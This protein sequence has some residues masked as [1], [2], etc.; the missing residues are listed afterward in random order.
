MNKYLKSSIVISSFLNFTYAANA[1]YNTA[2]PVEITGIISNKEL[3]Q[4]HLK[5]LKDHPEAP[6]DSQLW[7]DSEKYVPDHI[8]FMKVKSN[9]RYI[10]SDVSEPISNTPLATYSAS[11]ILPLPTGPLDQG[12][13]GTCTTFSAIGA[14]ISASNWTNYSIQPSPSCLLNFMVSDSQG[15][16]NPWNGATTYRVLSTLWKA[17]IIKTSTGNTGFCNANYPVYEPYGS[18]AQSGQGLTTSFNTYDS[19]ITWP[20]SQARQI[21]G[22]TNGPNALNLI[23]QQLND[24]SGAYPVFAF[25]QTSTYVTT[26]VNGV[27]YAAWVD[28]GYFSSSYH[29]IY[30]YGYDDNIC[31]QNS[32]NQTYQCGVLYLRNSWGD[33]PDITTNGNYLMTYQYFNSHFDNTN[34]IMS[35]SKVW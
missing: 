35:F 17:G 5:Y 4:E 22:G 3:I 27:K 12:N 8:R 23:K 29:A 28:T 30:V 6:D 33:T 11:K 21:N 26:Y 18:S 15:S 13:F 9:A 10:G 2:N 32:T 20:T 7:L 24:G 16:T 25:N 34:T 1:T 31:V 14:L 19:Q